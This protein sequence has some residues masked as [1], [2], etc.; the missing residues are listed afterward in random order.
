MSEDYSLTSYLTAI[1][2]SK[3][4]LMDT[5]DVTWE[6]KYPSYIINKGLSYYSD[7]VMYANEMNRLH[8]ASKHMQFSFLINT[9]RSQKRFSKWLKASKIKDLDAVKT[10]FGYSNNRAREALSVLTKG[11]IDY[12]KEKLYKGGKRK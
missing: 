12:I 2:W 4:K 10:Y 7:T 5:D 3:K 8:H 9:I 1:N 6:K 11:Q